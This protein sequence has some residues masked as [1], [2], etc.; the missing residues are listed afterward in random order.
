MVG[1]LERCCDSP[2][3]PNFG[4]EGWVG[5]CVCSE[6]AASKR[7]HGSPC[8]TS[9][10]SGSQINQCDLRTLQL[11]L[12]LP[13]ELLSERFEG[14]ARRMRCGSDRRRKFGVGCV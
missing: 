11:M 5:V 4:A 12:S 1:A 6:T 8:L 2:D 7:Y 9:E 13:V 14:T 10:N 3:S